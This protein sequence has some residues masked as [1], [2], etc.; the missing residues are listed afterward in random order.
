M[1][2]STC[3]GVD[4]FQW[5]PFKYTKKREKRTCRRTRRRRLFLSRDAIGR[6]R[7]GSPL[8]HLS[9]PPS[10]KPLGS[11]GRRNS[12]SNPSPPPKKKNRRQTQISTTATS[13]MPKIRHLLRVWPKNSR[14]SSVQV[15]RYRRSLTIADHLQS[16]LGLS[17]NTGYHSTSHQLD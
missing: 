2:Q 3:K 8:A 6:G 15:T 13:S 10:N 16:K 5:L 7:R 12:T 11:L 4:W 9:R 1:N 17:I 14:P